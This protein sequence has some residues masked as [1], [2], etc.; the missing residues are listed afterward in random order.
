MV[1]NKKSRTGMGPPTTEWDIY[2]DGPVC[3]QRDGNTIYGVVKEINTDKNYVYLQPLIRTNLFGTRFVFV[4]DKP[5][6]VPA[7]G[8]IVRPLK[9]GELENFVEEFNKQKEEVKRKIILS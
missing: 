7:Q 8:C 6:M 9:D 4:K 2:K 5:T 3:V 1:K